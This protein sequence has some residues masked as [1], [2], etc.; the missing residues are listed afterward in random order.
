VLQ[1]ISIVGFDWLAGWDKSIPD[2]LTTAAQDFEAFGRHAANLLLDR[3]VGDAPTV[4]RHVLFDAPLVMR[5]ST[6]SDLMLPGTIPA[7]EP[8]A[9]QPK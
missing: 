3:V 1:D 9:M 5:S 8:R 2:T 6:V 4:P 7:S